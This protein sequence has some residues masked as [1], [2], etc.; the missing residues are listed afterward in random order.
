MI[1][2]G[3]ARRSEIEFGGSLARNASRWFRNIAGD[4]F[5]TG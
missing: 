4:G 5:T 3:V 2:M 1:F